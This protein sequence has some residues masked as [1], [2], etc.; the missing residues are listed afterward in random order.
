MRRSWVALVVLCSAALGAC[1]AEE[2]TPAPHPVA[3]PAGQATS[4][5]TWSR[6]NRRPQQAAAQTVPG[7]APGTF[8][9]DSSQATAAVAVP[10]PSTTDTPPSPRRPRPTLAPPAT[11]WAST[12]RR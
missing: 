9:A 4:R 8:S 11:P 3:A 2:T 1:G 6:T 7:V 10:A 5:V 12:A